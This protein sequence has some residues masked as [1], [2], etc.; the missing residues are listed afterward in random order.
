MQRA[1]TVSAPLDSGINAAALVV[2][3]MLSARVG[4]V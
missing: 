3:N 2:P 1:R 4:G